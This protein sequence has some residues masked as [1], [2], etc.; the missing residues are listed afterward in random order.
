MRKT[1]I[2]C[3]PQNRDSWLNLSTCFK[4]SQEIRL[5]IC[6]ANMIEGFNRQL[7]KMTQA[8]TAFPTDGGLLKMLYLAMVDLT[9][10]GRT[11]HDPRLKGSL[12]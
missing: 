2:P 10:K 7:R 1:P 9:K 11:V 8:E 5:P 6:T 4:L 3:H 12:F